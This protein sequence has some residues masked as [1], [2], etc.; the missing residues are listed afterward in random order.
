MS[1]KKSIHIVTYST[2]VNVNAFYRHLRVKSSQ[3][4]LKDGAVAGHQTVIN[5]PDDAGCWRHLC[6][7]DALQV[8]ARRP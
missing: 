6:H 1:D 4:Y 3:I 7:L 8:R 2:E 5:D